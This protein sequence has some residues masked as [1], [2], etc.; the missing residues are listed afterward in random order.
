MRRLIVHWVL[1]WSGAAAVLPV[2]NAQQTGFLYGLL[3]NNRYRAPN[4]EYTLSL[5]LRIELGGE[6]VDTPEVVTLQDHVSLHAS[7]ACF[8][9][10][11]GLKRQDETLGRRDF[12]VSFFREH[13]HPQ[14][15]QRFEGAR[16]ESA[17]FTPEL[18]NGALFVY[19]LLPGGS[20]F[21]E[22]V[23]TLPDGSSP[24]AKRG[25]LLFLHNNHIY[26]LSIELAEKV[27][28]PA[29]FVMDEEEQNEVLHQRLIELVGRMTFRNPIPLP[30][31][32]APEKLG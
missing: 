24:I 22:R 25:N 7:V 13:V 17:R 18:L 16:I 12:L 27:L 31:I 30:E 4:G 3:E 15:S 32:A 14:F 10:N 26:V 1:A 20:M 28:D 6:V 21:G 9:L 23:A 8:G 29:G 2:A 19:N 5:P 11:L